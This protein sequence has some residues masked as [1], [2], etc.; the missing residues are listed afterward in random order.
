MAVSR[1]VTCARRIVTYTAQ[2]KHRSHNLSAI[3]IK[4]CVCKCGNPRCMMKQLFLGGHVAAGRHLTRV[5]REQL[6]GVQW[7]G[8]QQRSRRSRRP[9]QKFSFCM[10]AHCLYWLWQHVE[11]QSYLEV[12]IKVLVRAMEPPLFAP[13]NLT[14]LTK[15]GLWGV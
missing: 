7:I 13:G 15:T 9:P 11:W 2:G 5:F 3:C 10:D 1:E 14:P 12:S 6:L 8:R 4:F